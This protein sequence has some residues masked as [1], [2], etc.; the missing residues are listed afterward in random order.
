MITGSGSVIA[1]VIPLM[2]RVKFSSRFLFLATAVCAVA[3]FVYLHPSL[4]A[5]FMRMHRSS[6]R[7][8][9]LK[10]YSLLNLSDIDRPEFE[11]GINPVL[12]P[13]LD[14]I[15]KPLPG[16]LLDYLS[17]SMPKKRYLAY[18]WTLLPA[19]EI[20]TLN[21]DSEIDIASMENGYF[22]IAWTDY[23]YGA[24]SLKD[25]RFYVGHGFSNDGSS[26]YCEAESIAD[27]LRK[28]TQ[29]WVDH[30]W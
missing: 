30:E 7:T 21:S 6:K 19:E 26:P 20:A 23:G 15:E 4:P 27:L 29:A 28:Q 11:D 5:T 25:G 12:L 22:I 13:L 16:E 18:H 17:T 24:V 1:A 10:L 9:V 8:A 3:L 2:K 14:Q